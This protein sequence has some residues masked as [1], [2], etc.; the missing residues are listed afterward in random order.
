MI[1]VYEKWLTSVDPVMDVMVRIFAGM[2]RDGDK[3]ERGWVGT[4]VISVPMRRPVYSYHHHH[5]LAIFATYA[6]YGFRAS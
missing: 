6:S 2:G 4:G 5:A 1:H 3:P